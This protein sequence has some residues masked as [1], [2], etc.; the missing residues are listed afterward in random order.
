LAFPKEEMKNVKIP[1]L[2]FD[3]EFKGKIGSIYEEILEE[4][5]ISLRDF[6]IRQLPKM[7]SL[8]EKRDAFVEVKDLKI[9]RLTTDELYKGKKK[10]RV[11]FTLPKGSYATILIRNLEF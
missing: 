3:T 11:S 9:G 2:N 8:S 1:L 5:G 6:I 10:Q 4:E 7:V